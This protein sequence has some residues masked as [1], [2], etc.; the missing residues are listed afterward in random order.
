MPKNIKHFFNDGLSLDE[1]KVSILVVSFLCT[2][3]FALFMYYTTGDISSN[4]TTI[5]TAQ[6]MAVAGVN[7]IQGVKDVIVRKETE[8]E[9]YNE[10]KWL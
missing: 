10:D 9:Y 5:I 8:S 3:I 6:I 2:I 7:V 4:L 1:T